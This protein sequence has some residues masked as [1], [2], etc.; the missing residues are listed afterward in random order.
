MVR[1]GHQQSSGQ[2]VEKHRSH[3][4]RH[5]MRAWS[6]EVPVDDDDGGGDVQYCLVCSRNL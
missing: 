6:L 4:A 1:S 3:P 2:P 5:A